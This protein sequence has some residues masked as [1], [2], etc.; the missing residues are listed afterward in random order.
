MRVFDHYYLKNDHELSW[1]GPSHAERTW[2]LNMLLAAGF[3]RGMIEDRSDDPVQVTNQMGEVL[4]EVA[5]SQDGR[6]DLCPGVFWF[7]D[8]EYDL[9]TVVDNRGAECRATKFIEE[10]NCTAFL[11]GLNPMKGWDKSSFD[12]NFDEKVNMLAAETS[13]PVMPDRD[14]SEW[15][16]QHYGYEQEGM[17]PVGAERAEVLY[18]RVPLH[19]LHPDNLSTPVMNMQDVMDH[20]NNDGLFGITLVDWMDHLAA[21]GVIDVRETPR[22]RAMNIPE[23]RALKDLLKEAKAR[24]RD[25]GCQEP[26]APR[27][28]PELDR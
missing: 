20:A 1:G 5:D 14:L 25:A 28:S 18:G 9:F 15:D 6:L 12:P 17:L 2:A 19:Q 23:D 22:W 10:R 26:G 13:C 4:R 11:D 27:K 16:M 21:S 8:G 3:T 7:Y 24:A